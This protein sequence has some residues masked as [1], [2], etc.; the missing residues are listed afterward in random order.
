MKLLKYPSLIATICLMVSSYTA[1][2]Q[3]ATVAEKVV[4][5]L[6]DPTGTNYSATSLNFHVGYVLPL[7][8][9]NQ[10]N[11]LFWN[12][13]GYHISIASQIALNKRFGAGYQIGFTRVN[14]GKNTND[15]LGNTFLSDKAITNTN[16]ID[17]TALLRIFLGATYYQPSL[18]FGIGNSYNFNTRI[19][20]Q[21]TY[22][23]DNAPGS[24]KYKIAA[25]KKMPAHA[26][27]RINLTK[28]YIAG[29]YFF[30]PLFKEVPNE[31]KWQTQFEI[32][33]RF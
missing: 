3:K 10:N 31:I 2:A 9:E 12:T 28:F 18:D 27:F 20:H 11:T 5:P 8:N 14:Y 21:G 30:D 19:I 6:A 32:G 29:K 17:V 7:F 4:T 16:L 23:P 13:G 24:L 22:L 33:L 25:N 26:L 15:S 1:N